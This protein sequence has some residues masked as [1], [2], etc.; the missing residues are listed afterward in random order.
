MNQLAI[1]ADILERWLAVVEYEGY[2]EVSDLGRVR[3][4][5][6][7]TAAGWR[8]GQVLKPQCKRYFCV[9]LYRDR[10]MRTVT[11]HSLVAAAF[12]GPCPAGHEICHGRAGKLENRLTNLSYGTP[13]KNRG[14]D[15]YRDGTIQIGTRNGLARLTDELVRECRVRSAAGAS[16]GAL[17]R[18]HGVSAS[19]V[20]AAVIGLTWKHVA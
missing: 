12:L 17:A 19:T 2:Y 6:R 9:N 18:E 7:M 5:R 20:R 13:A 14:P 10:K 8:G 3:S 16:W 4:L 11:V 1:S 15:K